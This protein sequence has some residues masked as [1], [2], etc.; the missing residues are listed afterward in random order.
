MKL[1]KQ[2]KKSFPLKPKGNTFIKRLEK[3]VKYDKD[4][5]VFEK[6][7]SEIVRNAEA[8]QYRGKGV[9][10]YNDNLTKDLKET[11]PTQ[12][13]ISQTES[14]SDLIKQ[15]NALQEVNDLHGEGKNFSLV[16][17]INQAKKES[18]KSPKK[19]TKFQLK[20]QKIKLRM[21][22]NWEITKQIFKEIKY[23]AIAEYEIIRK[24]KYAISRK[25]QEAKIS[26]LFES[27]MSNFINQHGYEMGMKK[28]NRL[29]KGISFSVNFEKR[30]VN[31]G[32]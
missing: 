21:K 30:L 12:P 31:K 29:V 7:F 5:E 19:K 9:K 15:L 13:T 8:M 24:L 20:I 2:N 16:N 25:K 27:N 1:F 28:Y 23:W 3:A 6:R 22:R 14:T 26:R 11:N 32:Y 17:A 4:K 10:I 18:Q